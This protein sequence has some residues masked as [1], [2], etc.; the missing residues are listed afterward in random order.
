MAIAKRAVSQPVSVPA[1]VGGWNARDSLT[2][3]APTDA[4]ILQN[5]FPATTECVLRNGYTQYA[6]G[7]T[8]Q[9]ETLMAYSGA[10]T[11]KLFAIAGTSVYDVSAGGAVGA[12]VVTGLTNARWGYLNLATSGGNYLS[13]A[14]GT[15]SPRLYDGSTWTTPTITGVTATTLMYP[16]L[17]AQR[18]FFMQK[19]SLK[20]W[21]LPLDS[22]AG[23]AAAIDVA[24]FATKG[25]YIVSHGTWTVDAGQ[26]VND[27]YV[28]MTNRGQVIVFQ[29]TDPS[30]AADWS[31]VGVWDIG[32][33]IGNRALYKYAG[34]M[35][36]IC[37]DG[38]VPLSGALQSSRVQPR[39]ALSDKIQYAIS[40]AITNYGANFGWQV[41]Y[42][43]T[44]NQ[45]WLNVP[46][47]EGTNQQ[48]YVM[49]TIT[50]SW[51]TYTGWNAN[52]MEL[53]NDEPYFGGN[54]YVAHAYFGN[55]DNGNNINGFGLQAFNN[56]QSAGK[57][58][59]FTMSRPIF[60]S[61]G[62]PSVAAAVN[63]DFNTD[64]PIASLTYTPSTYA[65]W[66]SALWDE[67]LWGGGLSVFQNWQG[68]N[69]VG[70]Y[71][72]PVVQ[73]AA[74]GIEVRWVSTDLVIE[75]GAIL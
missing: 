63:I 68:V 9:V 20:T 48:Q 57:L 33:P 73:T 6:T 75:P 7:I 34:D 72:A 3:M 46:T 2:A 39:V 38:L 18:Q 60:R 74:N 17:Y 49:N 10:A 42:V 28:V 30:I 25:G 47:Q 62:S 65:K 19:N 53:F 32:A 51:C 13:M 16:I 12:A 31:M 5:W 44:I 24:P 37:Q 45:L 21:Y 1:P 26:G 66:D 4:V 43:P 58:K 61:N 8:G 56:F 11:S 55:S 59:R 54:G 23:A 41:M 64:V 71:G 27:H 69:G 70:Y 50:G 29:G 15:D 35:L 52:C 67:A 14:N 40:E 22:V 36:V